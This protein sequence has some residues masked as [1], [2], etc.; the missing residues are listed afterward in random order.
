MFSYHG[1][2]HAFERCAQTTGTCIIEPRIII[3]VR[4][5]NA[6]CDVLKPTGEFGSF[7][8]AGTYLPIYIGL[9]K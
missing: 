9:S 5:K 2:A 6:G 1:C 8:D 7:Y 4:L 3:E